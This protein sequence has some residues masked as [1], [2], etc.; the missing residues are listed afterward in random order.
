V[1]G[2]VHHP[3]VEG[4][5]TQAGHATIGSILGKPLGMPG[6]KQVSE[7]GKGSAVAE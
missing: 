1:R 5:P 7:H 2:I 4:G 3:E 6:G